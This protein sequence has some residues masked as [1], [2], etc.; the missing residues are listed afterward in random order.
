MK[1]KLLMSGKNEYHIIC[2]D[3]SIIYNA[4]Y[5]HLYHF[6]INFNEPNL[7]IGYSNTFIKD[8]SLIDIEEF[9]I[10]DCSVV[11]TINDCNLLIVNNP[12]PLLTVMFYNKSLVNNFVTVKEYAMIHNKA[13]VTIK[14]YC[15]DNKLVCI[16]KGHVWLIDPSC[17]LPPDKRKRENR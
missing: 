14:K 3:R 10:P 13:T 15:A 5:E 1:A 7:L 17:P 8:S 4:S 11:A 12:T 16:K 2:P 9:M 6:I